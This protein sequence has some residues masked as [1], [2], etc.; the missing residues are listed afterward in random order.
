MQR[1]YRV[2]AYTEQPEDTHEPDEVAALRSRIPLRN[3]SRSQP[4]QTP[5]KESRMHIT[6]INLAGLATIAFLVLFLPS[7]GL[8]HRRAQAI[9]KRARERD[10]QRELEKL[11]VEQAEQV[12]HEQERERCEASSR[13]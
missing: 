6:D 2:V 12:I 7:T 4:L 9:A 5:E 13:S 1:A 8:I 10:Q 11:V 3:L